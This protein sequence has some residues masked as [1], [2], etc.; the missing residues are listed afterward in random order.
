[1]VNALKALR[2]ES[3]E[4]ILMITGVRIG[5]S[6]ARDQRI[7]LSCGR[8]GA[9][10]GQGWFQETTPASVADTLAPLLHWR[11]CH[12][13]EWLM[14]FAPHYGLPTSM[15]AEVYGGEEAEE[16][17]ART[18]CIGCPLATKD[19]AL[20]YILKMDQWSYLEPLKRLRPL[21]KELRLFGNRLQKDGERLK[22]GRLSSNPNRKGPLTMD[23][24]RY[25]LSVVLSVQSEINLAADKLGREHIDLINA[26]EEAR[27]LE[28]IALNQW[29]DRWDGTE[30]RGD[31][32]IP[33]TLGEGIV[34][35]IMFD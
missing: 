3:G 6:A 18:G 33:Q 2:D 8:N 30:P 13:W 23:A 29:P 27:I 22:S 17:N 24:R 16:V 11:V 19:T 34:Q 26:D 12:V 15:V 25:G 31:V 1:M 5:E 4:K 28:L 32:L 21:Y 14:L 7:A 9:E 20:D 10:C 35:P